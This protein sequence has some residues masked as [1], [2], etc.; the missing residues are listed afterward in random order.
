M[1]GRKVQVGGAKAGARH[2]LTFVVRVVGEGQR[3]GR[4]D[5]TPQFAEQD[6]KHGHRQALVLRVIQEVDGA[7]GM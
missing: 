7:V 1:T 3:T 6:S 5:Q 4:D 2:C